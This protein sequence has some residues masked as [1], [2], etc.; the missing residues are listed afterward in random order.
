MPNIV[1][2]ADQSPKVETVP[3]TKYLIPKSEIDEYK[4]NVSLNQST[5]HLDIHKWVIENHNRNTPHLPS[6]LKASLATNRLLSQISDDKYRINALYYLTEKN[7]LLLKPPISTQNRKRLKT[8]IEF[9]FE[10]QNIS[11]RDAA[12]TIPN[13]VITKELLSLIPKIKSQPILKHLALNFNKRGIEAIE[14]VASTDDL[15]FINKNTKFKAIKNRSYRLLLNRLHPDYLW[16]AAQEKKY[17]ILFL[18]VLILISIIATW[19]AY[20]WAVFVIPLPQIILLMMYFRIPRGTAWPGFI[21]YFVVPFFGLIVP[22]LVLTLLSFFLSLTEEHI[23]FGE[24]L[25]KV[26]AKAMHL[27]VA[28]LCAGGAYIIDL[29]IFSSEAYIK[30]GNLPT[31]THYLSEQVL[32]TESLW[33]YGLYLACSVE[34]MLIVCTLMLIFCLFLKN[35]IFSFMEKITNWAF[36]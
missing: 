10:F 34:I 26:F 33:G 11:F 2:C 36:S 35:G 9:G 14:H 31:G 28:L 19:G 23:S 30:S 22:A 29:I 20:C 3:Y 16:M 8:I 5:N 18:L 12:L 15:V 21:G 13:L 6:L 32:A 4:L 24:F 17:A 25:D 1:F 27:L 7:K